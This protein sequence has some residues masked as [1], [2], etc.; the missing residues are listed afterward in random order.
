[1]SE[2]NE[3]EKR[4]SPQEATYNPATK[5]LSVRYPD[6]HTDSIIIDRDELTK[7]ASRADPLD[8][9]LKGGNKGDQQESSTQA[10]PSKDKTNEQGQ[11]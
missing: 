7:V 2:R 5:E 9:K 1:L 8:Y 3:E 6:G 4:E 11:K 10:E